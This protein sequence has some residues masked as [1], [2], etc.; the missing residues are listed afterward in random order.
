MNNSKSKINNSSPN[1]LAA[2]VKIVRDLKSILDEPIE[3]VFCEFLN[4]SNVFEWRIYFEGPEGTPYQGG[5][6][7]ARMTFPQDYPMSP[8]SLTI[9]SEFWH[10]NVYKDGR[11]CISILHS[12]GNDPMSGELPEERWMPTQTVG[13]IMLSFQSMLSD[14]NIASPANIDASIMWRDKKPDYLEKTAKLVQNANQ[15]VPT[16]VIIPHPD[17]DP[18]QR[19]KRL[20]KMKRINELNSFSLAN[21]E[22]SDDMGSEDL[23]DSDDEIST[24]DESN[25]KIDL[26]DCPV[27]KASMIPGNKGFAVCTTCPIQHKD[28]KFNCGRKCYVLDCGEIRPSGTCDNQIKSENGWKCNRNTHKDDKNAEENFLE[29]MM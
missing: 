15:R 5:I 1:G 2:S 21:M 3:G 16:H 27:C 11:V 8:P 19:G 20:E 7:E 13:T 25:V 10:P 18:I 22:D 6:F 12:P 9:M 26:V 29:T 14:P 17:T 23:G 24:E 28:K 4:E